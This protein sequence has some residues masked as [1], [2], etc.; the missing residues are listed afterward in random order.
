MPQPQ[1]THTIRVD[2]QVWRELQTRRETEEMTEND[3]LRQVLDLPPLAAAP[4]PP[5]PPI[6][7]PN[8]R[9]KLRVTFPDGTVI[10]DEQVARTFVRTIEKIGPARVFQL[11]IPMAGQPLVSPQPGSRR[12]QWKP[13]SNGRYHVNTGSSTETK[14]EQ[15]ER[16]R[17]DLGD[18]FRVEVV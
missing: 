12:T 18:D 7:K 3:V 6:H 5:P 13:L 10:F 8:N 15:L 9:V 4:P 11:Q 17:R 1:A 16:I 14:R 2:F